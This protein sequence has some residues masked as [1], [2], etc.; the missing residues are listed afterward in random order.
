MEDINLY[1]LASAFNRRREVAD[2]RVVDGM[3]ANDTVLVKFTDGEMATFGM[4]D[5]YPDVVLGTLYADADEYKEGDTL[6]D[7]IYHDFEGDTDYMSGVADLIAQREPEPDMETVLALFDRHDGSDSDY[8]AAH[9]QE[10]VDVYRHGGSM[11]D[12]DN[13]VRLETIFGVKVDYDAY[14]RIDSE[15]DDL[16]D[17]LET[18]LTVREKMGE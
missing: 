16:E 11:L 6:E 12:L 4:P 14:H 2:A 10:T 9:W 5:G 18:G 8:I 1:D 15:V 7:G 3:C 17:W 13:I